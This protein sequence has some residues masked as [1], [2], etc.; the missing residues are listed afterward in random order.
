MK[1]LLLLTVSGILAALLL[2]QQNTIHE[3]SSHME[4]MQYEMDT[5]RADV[6]GAHARTALALKMTMTNQNSIQVMQRKKVVN[7][8]AYSP[9]EG[10]TDDTPFFTATNRKVRHGIV[11]VSRDLF[12]QGWVFGRKVYI[13]SLGIFTI[14]DL[15]AETK[16][17]QID[18]FMFDTQEALNF[19]KRT[20][21]AHLLAMNDVP[22]S[23]GDMVLSE[24]PVLYS[25][26]NTG[27]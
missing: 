5:L 23:D 9:R 27:L 11:A 12:D 13:K 20:L 19:G 26:S 4:T 14:D 3:L 8:T 22:C 15:M 25:M 2:L 7:V 17:N 21:E 24:T 6:A 1:F 10:E 18:I 16:R